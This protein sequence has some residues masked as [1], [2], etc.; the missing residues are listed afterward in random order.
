MKGKVLKYYFEN[1]ENCSQASRVFKYDRR[2]IS[3]WIKKR[4]QIENATNKRT[5][6]RI[7][8]KNEGMYP[9]MERALMSW[10]T[11]QRNEKKQI[12]TG[13]VILQ[14]CAEFEK[15]PNSEKRKGISIVYYYMAVL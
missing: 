10:I 2:L 13:L 9:T 11:T 6:C 14:A 3:R 7:E 4:D 8:N 5:K 1:G 15:L 12:H